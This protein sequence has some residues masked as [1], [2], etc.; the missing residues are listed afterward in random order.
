MTPASLLPGFRTIPEYVRHYA[1]AKPGA[2]AWSGGGT[3]LT[4]GEA[5]SAV[6]D[7]TRAL[8]TAGIRPGDVVAV[9]GHSRPECLIAFLACCRTGSVYLGLSPKY[10]LRELEFICQ[11]ARPCLLFV[12]HGDSDPAQTGGLQSMLARVPSIQTVVTSSAD[13]SEQGLSA[14]CVRLGSFLERAG[15]GS[16]LEPDRDTPAGPCAI[17]YTSG[18]TG[19]PKGALLSQ[20]GM[21]RSAAVSWQHWY[22]AFPDL[23]MVAQHP[24]NHV[25]WLVCECVTSVIAGGVLFFRERFDGEATL[26]LIERERLNM[27]LAFPSMVMLAMESPAFASC[28]LSSLRRIAFG[29][30]PSIE[31]MTRLR[32]RTG[33]VFSV[34]YGL[35]EAHGGSVTVTDD[36]AAL[37]VVANSIGRPV[38]GIEV[39]IVD[40]EDRVVPPGEPGEFLIRDESLFL[41]YLNRPQETAAALAGGWLHT[42]DIIA[43]DSAGLFVFVGRKKEMFKSGGYNVYP[44]EVENVICGHPDVS[45]AAVVQAPD[46]LWQEVGFAFVVPREE[47]SIDQAELVAYLRASLANYKIPKRFVF[48]GRLPE[49]PNGK[50]DK[51]ELRR[52]ARQLAESGSPE[53][54]AGRP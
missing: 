27:W 35:T 40:A 50:F 7:Y 51:V 20:Q 29:M 15:S 18:S 52:R 19:P 37:S 30:P 34:S 25:G 6:E 12:L 42:G 54:S 45:E 14:A 33:A 13:W 41:G 46:P 23:R 24:I 10:T 8:R 11:D 28:D 47:V 32:A 9:F 44:R 26:R 16:R 1:A 39:R 2:V 36:D 43:Q 3:S 49:L 22:G 21:I 31:L 48:V 53:P 4:F 17:V 38:S 5:S